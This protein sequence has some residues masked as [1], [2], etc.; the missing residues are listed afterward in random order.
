VGPILERGALTVLYTPRVEH[1]LV[2]GLDDVQRFFLVLHPDRDRDARLILVG[3]KRLP[4]SGRPRFWTAVDRIAPPDLLLGELTGAEYETKTRGTRYQ[5]P[6]RLAAAGRYALASHD[7]HTHLRYALA[8]PEALGPVHESLRLQRRGSYI[9]AVMNPE[10]KRL[11]SRRRR[12]YYR[13]DLQARFRDRRFAPADP[14]LL[15]VRD[16]ELV[17]IPS[18]KDPVADLAAPPVDGLEVLGAYGLPQTPALLRP[19]LDGQWR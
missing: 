7:A 2:L 1:P 19:A 9:A 14:A 8:L 16:A 17:L 3:R 12:A 11:G 13:P 5:P 4:D 6:A 18:P 10:R 15:G